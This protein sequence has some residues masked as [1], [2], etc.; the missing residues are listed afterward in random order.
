MKQTEF[1]ELLD[2]IESVNRY[3]FSSE[4]K[5]YDEETDNRLDTFS[6]SIKLILK[7]LINL[8]LQTKILTIR[9]NMET[10]CKNGCYEI[11][12]FKSAWITNLNCRILMNVLRST[13]ND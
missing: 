13:K 8:Q 11:D 3:S 6:K 10:G 1:Q 7:H 5:K 12:E 4:M 2:I 9:D